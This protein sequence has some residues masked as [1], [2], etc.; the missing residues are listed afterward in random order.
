MTHCKPTPRGF[1]LIE[2]LVVIAIISLLAAIL[3]PLFQRARENARRSSCQSNLKQIG[4]AFLQYAG[5]YDERMAGDSEQLGPNSA[6]PNLQIWPQTLFPYGKNR[7]IYLCPSALK[8][9]IFTYTASP[10]NLDANQTTYA[11]NNVFSWN[12]GPLDTPFTGTNLDGEANEAGH[13]GAGRFLLAQAVAP[14]ETFL[15]TDGRTDF[16]YNVGWNT[17]IQAWI[18]SAGHSNTADNPVIGSKR[19]F[20]GM[21]AL[22]YDGHVKWKTQSIKNDW[23]YAT[24]P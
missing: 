1:T 19:H 5:D 8:T 23:P 2:L 11:Y 3:F 20:A 17:D 15:L 22:Y 21:C 4:L 16:H 14:A 18:N 13:I 12:G 7:Q 6:S 9:E 10:Y 24:K